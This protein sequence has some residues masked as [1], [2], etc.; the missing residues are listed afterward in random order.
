MNHE[1]NTDASAV[2]AAVVFTNSFV[3]VATVAAAEAAAAPAAA[4]SSVSQ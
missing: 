2:S 4:A 3:L 1:I